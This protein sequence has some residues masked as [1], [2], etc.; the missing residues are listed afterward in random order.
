MV[1]ED[2][3]FANLI[4]VTQ[5]RLIF[6]ALNGPRPSLRSLLA[7]PFKFSTPKS[8]YQQRPSL[9]GITFTLKKGD[10]L[11][12]IGA[13]GAGKSTLLRML[14]GIYVPT[15]GQYQISQEPACLFD[16]NVGFDFEASGYANIPIAAAQLGFDSRESDRIRKHVEE[17][18]ELGDSLNL[19][20]RAMSSGMQMRLAFSIA[21]YRPSSILLIDEIVGVGDSYF[22]EKAIAYVKG[23]ISTEGVLVIASHADNIIRDFCNLG[24]VLEAGKSIFLGSVDDAL[25]CYHQSR[26]GAPK[27]LPTEF[28]AL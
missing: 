6:P 3:N 21:I 20:I 9:D 19:P 10:R 5:A 25:A 11:G 24:L 12:L 2:S 15:S 8:V 28:K 17:F 4:A 1:I 14:A 18:S 13:N 7:S 22:I 23:R 26:T 16:L 27:T